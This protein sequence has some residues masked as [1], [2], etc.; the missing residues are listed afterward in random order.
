MKSA[1]RRLVLKRAALGTLA[2]AVGGAE[3]LL[4][5]RAALARESR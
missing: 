4:S 2:Y 5:P 3:V 1:N